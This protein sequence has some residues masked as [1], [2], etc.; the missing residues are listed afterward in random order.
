MHAG[1]QCANSAM[2][3][4]TSAKAVCPR[5]SAAEVR[6]RAMVP[7]GIIGL[8]AVRGVAQFAVQYALTSITNQG[9]VTACGRVCAQAFW[10][11]GRHTLSRCARR[12]RFARSSPSTRAVAA[13]L[14][15]CRAR[16][17]VMSRR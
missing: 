2:D 15:S 12:T 10:R 16:V 7:V 4:F 11:V 3:S 5:S 1:G 6:G 9:M 13:T 14:P 17:R 8:F